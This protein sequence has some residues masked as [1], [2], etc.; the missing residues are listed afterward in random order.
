MGKR[1][2]DDP[3]L[4]DGGGWLLLWFIALALGAVGTVLGISAFRL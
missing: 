3:K 4:S 1:K 2:E